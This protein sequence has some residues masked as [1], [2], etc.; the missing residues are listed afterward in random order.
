[1]RVTDWMRYQ[2]FVPTYQKLVGDQL[3]LQRQIATGKSILVPS[4]DTTG[5]ARS[6]TYNHTLSVIG[7]NLRNVEEATNWSRI[8]ESAVDTTV[9]YVQRA[10]ELA[11]QAT[12]FTLSGAARQGIAQEL[13]Q[14]I[15]GVIEA[16]GQRHRGHAVFSGS[17][18]AVPAFSAVYG[19]GGEVTGVN[20][21]GNGEDR[22]TE[23]SPGRNA[24]Y[25]SLGSNEKGG[26]FG[27]FRDTT[28]GIDVFNT[29][30]ELRDFVIANDSA[31]ITSDSIAELNNGLAHLT[32]GLARLGGMQGRMIAANNVNED[33]HEVTTKAL[34]LASET[35]I[36]AAATKFA[37]LETAYKA[38]LATG[39]RMMNLSLVD[40]LG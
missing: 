16:A 23:I 40:Y 33:S 32:E 39:A 19:A 34:A 26:Q 28:R 37:Q 14:I 11:I 9:D 35:D 20:H 17:L 10:Q 1:M 22:M 25:N 4:D 30:I 31:S 13:E 29:L 38:A 2:G 27:I 21:D 7:Q 24:V 5:A 3:K 15:Q 6:Q 12:D 36:A 8:T 18:T